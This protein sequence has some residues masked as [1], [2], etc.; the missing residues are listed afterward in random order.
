MNKRLIFAHGWATDHRVF[1][2]SIERLLKLGNGYEIINP[3]L[4][5]HGTEPSESWA[6]PTLKSSVDKYLE[7]L[8]NSPSEGPLFAIGW[9]LGAQILMSVELKRP[10]IFKGLVLV[11]ATPRAVSK[12]GFPFGHQRAL[13]KRM[14]IDL[15][16]EP[17]ETLERFY[18]LNFTDFELGEAEALEFL[19]R[20]STPEAK[21]D[22]ASLL[23]GLEAHYNTDIIDELGSLDLPVLVIHGTE[24]QVAPIAAGRFLA[25]K[26]KGA[27]LEVIENVGHAPFLTEPDIFSRL[28][29]DFHSEI[30]NR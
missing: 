17:K 27:T 23:N 5:G 20:Y 19:N 11:G 13:V 25:K 3:D 21:R 7:I 28:V 1:E 9:S 30:L 8:E 6:E 10:G 4:P 18:S 29:D 26:I 14:M 22:Y 15:K 24:D 2:P 12:E 16:K